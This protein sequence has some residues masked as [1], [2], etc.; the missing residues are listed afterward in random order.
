MAISKSSA[1]IRYRSGANAACDNGSLR[2]H[3]HNRYLSFKTDA[4]LIEKINHNDRAKTFPQGMM[5]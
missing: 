1:E 5:P 2:R 3:L 4:Q